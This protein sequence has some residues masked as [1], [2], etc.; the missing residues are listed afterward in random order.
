[1]AFVAY[2]SRRLTPNV[3]ALLSAFPVIWVAWAFVVRAG[4]GSRIAGIMPVGFDGKPAGRFRCAWRSF[5]IWAPVTVLL[6]ASVW[7]RWHG[8][9]WVGRLLWGAPFALLPVYAILALLDPARSPVDR[10]SGTYQV[11]R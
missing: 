4:L 11:P 8:F 9:P 6:I 5:L 3:A 2:A 10:L 1:M 7:F